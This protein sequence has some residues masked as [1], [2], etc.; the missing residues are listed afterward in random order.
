MASTKSLYNF[1]FKQSFRGDFF[2]RE[3]CKLVYN[4]GNIGMK[5][6]EK[7]FSICICNFCKKMQKIEMI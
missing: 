5:G 4:S 7:S 1:T 2:S 6:N 3:T